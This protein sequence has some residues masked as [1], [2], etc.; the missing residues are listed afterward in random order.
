MAPTDQQAL[1][2]L[3]AAR[4]ITESTDLPT[5][6]QHALQMT[7]EIIGF[8]RIRFYLA[9]PKAGIL[10]EEAAEGYSVEHDLGAT[11]PLHTNGIL[12][13]VA[14][15]KTQTRVFSVNALTD[16]QEAADGLPTC[17]IP[18]KLSDAL[19]GV[20]VAD[21]PRAKRKISQHSV[22]LLQALTDF[23]AATIERI[24]REELAT[25]L[26]SLVS[27]ELRT[28]LT[29]IAAF[30]EMLADGDAGPI[31]DKQLRF[32][33]RIAA[34]ATQLQS[35]VEDLLELSRL[36]SGAETLLQEPLS[37]KPFLEDVALNILPQARAKNIAI[38]VSSPDDLPILVTDQRRLQQALS[39]LIDNAIK[40]SPEGTS[41]ALTAQRCCN[42]IRLSVTDQG[43]GIAAED[44]ERLFD[45]FFRCSQGANRSAERGSGLGL[46]IVA[47]LAEMLGADVEVSSSLGEGSTFA[48]LF[49]IQQPNST[50]DGP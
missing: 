8:E 3:E 39:N 5:A 11:V 33:Q 44:Q 16:C 1:A 20:I 24:R 35:I 9:I 43:P 10:R 40:Y 41:V 13:R 42:N 48:I 26:V 28:P 4:R 47:R 19:L 21:Y 50:S 6:M 31:N 25:K 37:I 18:L 17:L 14:S 15:G 22:L 36:Q 23:M 49:P 30:C 45:E 2:L 29:S 38:T 46:S 7:H 12:S 27:H 34:G 32:V